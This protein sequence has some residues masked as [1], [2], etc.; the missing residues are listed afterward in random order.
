MAYIYKII[1]DINQKIYIGKTE[2]TIQERFKEHLHD[3]SKQRNEKRPL[4]DAMKKYGIEHFSVQLVEETDNPEEREQYWI[5]YYDS[6]HNGYNATFGGDGKKYIDYDLVIKTYQEVH[7]CKKVSEM[8]NI[9]TDS[10]YN[11]LKSRNIQQVEKGSFQKEHYSKKVG[12]Y[13][14]D[15]ELILSFLS[16][17]DAARFLRDNKKTSSSVDGV[18]S[19]ISAVCKGRRKTAYG[20]IWRYL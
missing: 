10:V 7:N 8:L 18:I 3:F 15:N 9:C 2:K 20:Y 11:I 13:D 1:N 5:Q 19:H 4:Y 6:Y 16:L 17:G 14:K 12:A